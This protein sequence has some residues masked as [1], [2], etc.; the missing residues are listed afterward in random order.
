MSQLDSQTKTI[1]NHRFEVFK[2]PPLTAQDVLIDIGHVLAPA[3]GKAVSVMGEP[4]TANLFDL[5][6]DDPTISAGITALARGITKEK[7]RELVNT[8]AGVSHCDGKPLPKV[9]EIIFRGD[10]PLMYQ[11]LWFALAVNFGNFS[12]WLGS[13]IGDVSGQAAA[14]QSR[15]T[16]KDIGQ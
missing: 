9:M 5:D 2:L 3:L 7:M 11:W 6:V 8:M 4:N 10:L 16:S 14:A 1:G 15:N 13:A 12:K